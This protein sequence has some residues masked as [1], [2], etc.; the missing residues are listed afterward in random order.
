MLTDTAWSFELLPPIQVADNI[1]VSDSVQVADNIVINP[2]IARRN[3]V[4]EEESSWYWD[5]PSQPTKDPDLLEQQIAALQHEVSTLRQRGE[6]SADNEELNRLREENRNLTMNLEDLDAQHQLAMERLLTLKRELQ[7]NFE[8]LKQEHEELKS[9]NDDYAA[10]KQTLL[11]KVAERDKEIEEIRR[12]HADYETLH[13]KYMNLE[14]VHSLLRENAEKFQEENQELHEEIFRLQERVTKYEHEM[15]LATKHSELSTMVPR[16]NYEELLKELNDLK[17]Q[18]NSNRDHCDETNIDD[19]AKSVIENLKREIRELKYQV[20][21]KDND[22]KHPE[23]NVI[24]SEKIMQLYNKYVNFELPVDYIGEMPSSD[25]NIVLFKLQSSFR[26]L[27]SFKKEIDNL[28]HQ[29][30]EKQQH[31]NEMEVQIFDLTNENDFLGADVSQFQS[32]LKEM[33]KNNDFLINE[34]AAL[35][36]SSKLEP[37]IE[38]HEE[39]VVK[40]ESELDDCTKRNQNFVAQIKQIETELAEV[41]KEKIILQENLKEMREKYTSMLSEMESFKSKTKDVEDLE[42]ENNTKHTNKLKRAIDEIDDYKKKLSAANAKNEQLSIDIHI[43]ENDKVLLTKEVDDLKHMLAETV[44]AHQELENL[45]SALGTKLASLES[46][47]DEV[48]KNKKELEEDKHNLENK[49]S[50]LQSASKINELMSVEIEKLNSEKQSLRSKLD[51]VLKENATLTEK[52]E[53]ITTEITTLKADVELNSKNESLSNST[54]TESINTTEVLEKIKTLEAKVLKQDNELLEKTKVLEAKVLEQ[55]QLSQ[56]IATLKDEKQN[57]V[58]KKL[59]LEAELTSTDAKIAGLEEDFEKLIADLNEKDTIIDNLNATVAENNSTISNINDTITCLNTT[60]DIKNQEIQRLTQALNETTTKLNETSSR[61]DRESDELRQ[62]QEEKADLSKQILNFQEEIESKNTEIS[63]LTNK[64]KE[65]EVL[66]NEY[67]VTIDSK[68]K[69]MK[70]LNQSMVEC[71]D[72]LKTADNYSHLND[73]YAALLE[74]KETLEKEVSELKNDLMNKELELSAI[75]SNAD[76]LQETVFE[77]KSTVDNAC[78]E[79]AELI[80]LINLKHNESIQYHNEIQRLN[81]VI[82]EQTNEHRRL[83][84]EKEHLVKYHAQPN[85]DHC[86]NCEN[87]RMTLKEKDEIILTLN[88]NSTDHERLKTELVQANETILSLKER[89]ENLDKSLAIQLENVK[90]LT[91]EQTQLSEQEQN[92]A[93]ELERLRHHL[94]ETE[95][96]YTQELM[97]SEQ[98]LNECQARLRQVEE[99][100]KQTTTVYTSNSIRANQEV[101]TLRNQIKLLEKQREEVQARLSEADDARSRSEAALTNLQVV[102]EQ[103]QSDKE[104]DI[105][106]ATEKI[107]NKLSDEKRQNL[108]LQ[109]EIHRLNNKLEE[110]LAGLQAASRLGDQ[111]ESKTAQINDLKEQVRTLQISVAAA[112]ERYYNA[113]SNQQDKVDKHL[114][115]NLVINYVMTAAQNAT[116]KTQVLRILSTVLDFNKQECEKL[117]L[118]KAQPTDSLAAEFVKFLQNESKPRA[119]LPNMMGI[120]QSNSSRSTTPVSRKN[121]TLGPNPVQEMGHQRNLSAGSNNLLFQNLDQLETSSQI[122]IESDT[123]KRTLETGVTQTRDTEGAILKHVLR[124][125]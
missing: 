110:A 62:L 34:I 114:V 53:N 65:L 107:R 77:Y 11:A 106:A 76:Q 26:T 54:K 51:A 74:E 91:A 13:H 94:V 98:K 31:L 42:E 109:D 43:I 111:L 30:A 47:L 93:R 27:N 89:C 32:E 58:A 125:M 5:P 10:E 8:L 123:T 33:K 115:K 101:E 63:S 25:D 49:L 97:A 90:R 72:K 87:L 50:A 80:N 16:E 95:E 103:F 84:E 19:N 66:C 121:S 69:E 64:T 92:S 7:K 124:D 79:K 82:L 56:V 15:E 37:I 52:V 20:S 22:L 3:G 102:L 104:R 55:E 48:S 21:Q 28:Q 14:K 71:T 18:K 23:Q 44:S 39:N 2:K 88:K 78:K 24:K 35:K 61:S 100:A 96:N 68:D 75:K 59:Q 118:V 45:K 9:S 112:E 85:S 105:H 113:T 70:E 57:L 6:T 117:G 60:L 17:D 99:R 81:Q 41:K 36:N 83:V 40:L 38:T 29:L 86:A 119:P 46:K 12:G 73:E 122:S 67:K 108:A 116:S 1:Q 4:K 120:A